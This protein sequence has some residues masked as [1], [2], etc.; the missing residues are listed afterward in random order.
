MTSSIC[1]GGSLE[2]LATVSSV[3]PG[4]LPI[5]EPQNT[6]SSIVVVP[7]LKGQE[8]NILPLISDSCAA[9][10]R[11]HVMVLNCV[12]EH[13]FNSVCRNLAATVAAIRDNCE[14]RKTNR[15]SGETFVFLF[16]I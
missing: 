10:E 6:V 16:V 9:H 13:K 7:V 11:K 14:E 3:A 1:E 2:L 5:F 12:E 4:L 15:V 8:S